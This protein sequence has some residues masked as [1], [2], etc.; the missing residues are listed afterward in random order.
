VPQS[1]RNLLFVAGL[2]LAVAALAYLLASRT[3]EPRDALAMA[4][5]RTVGVAELDVPG[6]RS[7]ALWAELVG[8]GDA[9]MARIRSACGF[10]P[11]DAV[12][13]VDVFLLGN[14]ESA[15]DASLEE[16]AFVA[17]GALD[18]ALIQ[19]IEEIVA[20]DG[21]GVH[22]TVIEGVDA[23]ASDHG[24][25]VAAFYG[26]D[27][28]VAGAD[29]VVAELLRIRQ[30][31]SPAMP[32]DEGL[33]R[34]WGRAGSRRHLRAVARLP[35][36]WQRLVERVA[37]LG[38]LDALA[39]AR[40]LG[41]GA[42]LGEGIA[43]TVAIELADHDAADEARRALDGRARAVI[44]DPELGASAIA[45]A[46]RRLALEAR[47]RD[48]VAHVELDRAELEATVAAIRRSLAARERDDVDPQGGLP[49]PAGDGSL[50][51]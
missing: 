49:G 42:T 35:R 43:L 44:A 24:S 51:P 4:P 23:L 46:L 32:R 28:L 27:G 9:G 41:I 6:L 5:A 1:A 25:S 2:A 37:S 21:G 50:A 11:L 26:R 16:V 3:G 47:G 15:R 17:R 10:D 30:G 39:G 29:V 18:R 13:T 40:A 33:A 19:C 36:N 14:A 7:S 45:V 20:E 31:A 48:L 38:A 12:R 22:P 8:D 34:L